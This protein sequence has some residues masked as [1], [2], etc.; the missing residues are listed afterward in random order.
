[1][2]RFRAADAPALSALVSRAV[3]ACHAGLYAP[4]VL[5]RIES[6]LAP[7]ALLRLCDRRVIVVAETQ[8]EIIGTGAL[9][10]QWLQALFVDPGRQRRGVGAR[11]VRHLEDIALRGG[12]HRLHVYATLNAVSFYEGRGYEGIGQ[13]ENEEYGKVVAMSKALLAA[14]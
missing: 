3:R 9:E 12:R 6:D 11:L 14:Q 13:L 7:G 4:R 10:G 5:E 1:L 8:R 2:R